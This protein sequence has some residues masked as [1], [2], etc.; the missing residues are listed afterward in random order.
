VLETLPAMLS[1]RALA[2][3]NNDTLAIDLV[4]DRRRDPDR[5]GSGR[6]LRSSGQL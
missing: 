4:G 2:A 3:T 5:A 1:P 6:P